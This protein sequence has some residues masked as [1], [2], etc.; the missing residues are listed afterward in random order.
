[1]YVGID[2]HKKYSVLSA[3]DEQG[4][5]VREARIDGNTPDGFES[6][7][8]S[9][10]GPAKAVLEACWNWGY[11]YDLLEGMEGIEELVLAHPYKTRVIADAQIKTD[12]LD[13]RA[14]ANLLRGNLIPSAHIPTRETRSRK[15]LLR[16]RL[17][18]VRLRT[19]VRNRI[20]ALLARQRSVS[21]PQVS[22][23][24]GAKGMTFLSELKLPEP[25]GTLLHQDL[26]VLRVLK[27]Q[28]REVEERVQEELGDD[29]AYRRV[30]SMPGMGPIL[31]AVVATEIDGVHRFPSPSRL[32]A[33]AGLVPTT[34][35]SGGK[36][37]HGRL[38]P[39]C[40]KWLRWAFIEAA[41]VAIGCS[42]YFG[43]M[44]RHHRSRGKGAN[45]AITIIARRMAE[46]TWQILTKDRDYEERS[47]TTE[48]FPDRSHARLVA[49]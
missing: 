31:G 44:Y 35:A 41:W 39:M 1:M 18:W 49:Q 32:C 16:Q 10:G 47:F 37:S 40:N 28:V 33:Y 20:H 38:L 3:M 12:R 43:G 2:Y 13:A 48:T 14:L 34:Y 4:H 19:R 15:D 30:K 6:F 27:E 29:P 9:L 7:F 22:D 42:P 17:F 25:D 23:L 45:T 8:A 5:R 11:L 21:L 26:A 46:I 36:V 24:F